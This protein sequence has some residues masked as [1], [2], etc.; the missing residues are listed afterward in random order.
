MVGAV[1]LIGAF[2]APANAESTTGEWQSLPANRSNWHCGPTK[3]DEIRLDIRQTIKVYSQNCLV[4]GRRAVQSATVVRRNHEGENYAVTI[5]GWTRLTWPA[6]GG[7]NNVTTND[8]AL[9]SFT[10]NEVNV[11]YSRTKTISAGVRT[12]GSGGG[13]LRHSSGAES[14]LRPAGK[15]YTTQ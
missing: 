14:A 2:A 9:A 11:C 5:R 13:F 15:A 10:P 3:T 6:G 7:G 12:V 4:Q 1:T 8:C